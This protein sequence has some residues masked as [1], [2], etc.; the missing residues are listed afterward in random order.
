M[1]EIQPNNCRQVSLDRLIAGGSLYPPADVPTHFS[2]PVT[3]LIIVGCALAAWA[4][5]GLAVWMGI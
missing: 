2:R 5:V 1:T 3:L 4:I